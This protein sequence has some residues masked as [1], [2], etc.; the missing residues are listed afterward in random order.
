MTVSVLPSLLF[1]ARAPSATPA[2]ASLVERVR[3]GDPRAIAELYDRH[4]A[5]VYAFARRITGD[6]SS[7]WDLVQEVFLAVPKALESFRGESQLETFIVSI[8]VH[9]A[10]NHVRSAMRQRALRER[11]ALEPQAASESPEQHLARAQLRDQLRAAL[12]TLSLDH[13]TAFVLCDVEERSSVEV[14]AML[15][16]PE[17]T[18][19]TRLFY[20][21]KKLR[22]H[23]EASERDEEP[24]R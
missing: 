4:H 18:V 20:A 15:S 1:S 13:Q 22:A 10:K 8:A 23:F 7:A 21:R 12:D 2:P 17:A 16:V 5:R 6:E 9:R 14:A 24:S 3:A 19:R 11:A